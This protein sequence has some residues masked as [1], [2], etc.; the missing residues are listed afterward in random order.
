[1]Q[2]RYSFLTLA[3]LVAS[4]TPIAIAG[5]QSLDWKEDQ[6][7][8]TALAGSTSGL[9]I[10]YPAR[11][12]GTGETGRLPPPDGRRFYQVNGARLVY[13]ENARFYMIGGTT[14]PKGRDEVWSIRTET[15][16]AQ[17]GNF[18]RLQATEVQLWRPGIQTECSENH[19]LP[20]F[21]WLNSRVVSFR[22]YAQHHTSDP[23]AFV[24]ST[25]L[26][27]RLHLKVNVDGQCIR[28]D[29]EQM[30]PVQQRW[31]TY[32]F[33]KVPDDRAVLLT[34]FGSDGEIAQRNVGRGE[35]TRAA[36]TKEFAIVRAIE[37]PVQ[38]CFG[39]S[40]P[41]PNTSFW[42]NA[43]RPDQ[44]D[45]RIRRVPERYGGGINKSVYWKPAS[46]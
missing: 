30:V 19:E 3:T 18:R 22:E 16:E 41:I 40:V 7:V 20:Q 2:Y 46:N 33:E 12:E 25:K 42:Q 5:A 23:R 32:G 36:Y 11:S 10:L 27:D 9:V 17:K 45:I 13:D 43:W 39:F 4:A 21:N 6:T 44:T 28:S 29:G 24:R 15:V 8:C 14:A 35:K 34:L 31:E 37:S 38:S 1:M 26:Q